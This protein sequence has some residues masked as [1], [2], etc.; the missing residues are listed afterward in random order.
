MKQARSG[1]RSQ[2]VFT[3]IAAALLTAALGTAHAK[4]DDIRLY[5]FSS[6]ALTLGKGALLNFDRWIRR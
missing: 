2:G 5:G 3:A 1:S 6:G 4:D